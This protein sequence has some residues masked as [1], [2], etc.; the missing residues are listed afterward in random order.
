MIYCSKL[1]YTKFSIYYL[2][3]SDS[4]LPTSHPLPPKK[5][6][7]CLRFRCFCIKT[8]SFWFFG[9]VGV[10]ILRLP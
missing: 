5:P 4:K 7:G 8:T 1:V 9:A 6:C 2:I 3:F 10:V